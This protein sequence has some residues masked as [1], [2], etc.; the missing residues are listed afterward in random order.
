MLLQALGYVS[1]QLPSP[2]SLGNKEEMHAIHK[3]FDNSCKH[4]LA[5]KLHGRV[6]VFSGRLSDKSQAI[7]KLPAT[8][9]L[10]G[11]EV[12][13]ILTL[14]CSVKKHLYQKWEAHTAMC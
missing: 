14:R 1:P 3:V 4:D 6:M 7:A 5:D 2:I 8:C 12:G 9:A 13:I 11:K 10:F